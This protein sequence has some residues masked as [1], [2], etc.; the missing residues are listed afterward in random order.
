M[1]VLVVDDDTHL[2]RAIAEILNRQ[3]YIVDIAAN[4]QTAWLFVQSRTYDLILLDVML[5]GLDGRNL[6]EKFRQQGVSTPILLLTAR[7]SSQDK[8]IGLDAGADDYMIKPFDWEELLARIRALLRRENPVSPTVLVWGDLQLDP[9]TCEVHY[10]KEMVPLRRQEYRLLEMF[11][12]NPNRVFSCSRILEQLWAF[13][14]NPPLE[15]TVRAHIKTLRRKLKVVGAKEMIETVYGLGYRL[16]AIEPEPAIIL[17][18]ATNGD[19]LK[20]LRQDLTEVWREIQPE[21]LAQVRV[22]ETV[23][24]AFQSRKFSLS[25]QKEAIA[26]AHKLAG[27]VGI[28]GFGQA[29][30]LAREIETLLLDSASIAEQDGIAKL[31][32]QIT[33]LH[34]QLSRMPDFSQ[35]E[36]LPVEITTS[37]LKM[38]SSAKVLAVDDDP[39]L[40][41]YITTILSPWGLRLTTLT[42][43]HQ[44]WTHLEEVKPDLLLLDINMPGLSGLELCQ[45]IRGSDLWVALP[46]TVLTAYSDSK[47]MQQAFIA[48]ADDFISKPI[49]EAE[50]VTRIVTRINRNRFWQQLVDRDQLTQLPN[51]RKFTQEFYQLLQQAEQQRFPVSL[52]ILNLE[53]L[54]S[55]NQRYGYQV[56]DTLLRQVAEKISQSIKTDYI[57]SRW[58]G[59]KFAIAL[60][61]KNKTQTKQYL[62]GILQ[63]LNKHALSLVICV[64]IANFPQDG[65]DLETLYRAV[66]V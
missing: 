58:S 35:Q 50:L 34:N 61:H 45:Q 3:N 11:L 12:R 38:G 62:A 49:I 66:E 53:N 23:A 2:V 41:Q 30:Q 27:T 5:P 65:H 42:N 48:G 8:V 28:Y 63:D 16:K 15:E 19:L 44:L 9:K 64:E 40:L 39:N 46:V 18:E 14:D 51:R 22:L 57:I 25:L 17:G 47:T 29:S 52:C 10:G 13:D 43:P 26:N 4:G 1:R 6:C 60:D 24:N 7:D 21:I 31:K 56:G 54:K 32:A 59:N 36:S 20:E 55:I 33:A 37:L